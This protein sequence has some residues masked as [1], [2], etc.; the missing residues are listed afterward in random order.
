MG[1]I[2]MQLNGTLR[3]EIVMSKRTA[4]PFFFWLQRL[5]AGGVRIFLRLDI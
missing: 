3:G 5:G 2:Y 1:P 4:H